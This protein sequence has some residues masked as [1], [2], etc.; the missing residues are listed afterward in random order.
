MTVKQKPKKY[1]SEKV[2][3]SFSFLNNY[4]SFIPGGKVNWKPLKAKHLPKMS[5]VV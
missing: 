5:D 3:L 1:V 4:R 2:L